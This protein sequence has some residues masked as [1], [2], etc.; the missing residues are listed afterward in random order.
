MAFKKKGDEKWEI[1]Q[2]GA[3]TVDRTVK[4]A[5]VIKDYQTTA[6]I[7]PNIEGQQRHNK[8]IHEIGADALKMQHPK[9]KPAAKSNKSNK[10]FRKAIKVAEMDD[11]GMSISLDLEWDTST[12]GSEE[13]EA[14]CEALISVF[15]SNCSPAR[16][17][18]ASRMLVK[19]L[20][21]HTSAVN[22]LSRAIQPIIHKCASKRI[23]AGRS[24]AVLNLLY[25]LHCSMGRFYHELSSFNFVGHFFDMLLVE[26]KLAA[27]LI[28]HTFRV[29]RELKSKEFQTVGVL[30]RGFGTN[31][32]IMK[33]RMSSVNARS[34][35]IRRHWNLMHC[36]LQ[37]LERMSQYGKRGPVHVIENYTLVGLQIVEFLLSN[38]AKESAQSNREDLL[39][40]NGTILLVSFISAVEG[41][42][43]ATSIAIVFHLALQPDSLPD[44]IKS[45]LVRALIRFVN[46]SWK[47]RKK[48]HISIVLKTFGRMFRHAA[49]LYRASLGYRTVVQQKYGEDTNP[50]NVNYSIVLGEFN[51]S[52]KVDLP[53]VLA[54]KEMLQLHSEILTKELT[55]ESVNIT[56]QNLL[57]LAGS[58][59]YAKVLELIIGNGGF[60]L[61]KLIDYVECAAEDEV[62]LANSI[63]ALLTQLGTFGPARSALLTSSI[64]EM[65]LP[66][67]EIHDV[68]TRAWYHKYIFILAVLCRIDSRWV[69]EPEQL[70]RD[71]N[72]NVEKLQTMIYMDMMQTIKQIPEDSGMPLGDVFVLESNAKSELEMA[73]VAERVHIRAIVDYFVRPSDSFYY[74]R[75][76]WDL[77]ACGCS[78]ISAI[79]SVPTAA[80]LA[81]SL[82]TVRYLG[83][84]FF[85]GYTELSKK[86]TS[87]K[88][89]YCL[90]TG[91]FAAVEGLARICN[92][93]KNDIS[94]SRFVV[95]GI[96]ESSAA[97]AANYFF[98][99]LAN[100]Q[101]TLKSEKVKSLQESVALNCIQFL[102][103]YSSCLTS[104]GTKSNQDEIASLA[105]TVGHS[106]TLVLNHLYLIYGQTSKFTRILDAV[107]S[108]LTNLT[109]IPIA[110]NLALKSWNVLEAL[111]IH[112]PPP[113]QEVGQFHFE[114][115]VYKNHLRDLPASF[116]SVVSN[117]ASVDHGC[118]F[119]FAEGFLRRALDKVAIM[120]AYLETEEDF[121]FQEK[122]LKLGKTVLKLNN[123]RNEV[124]ACLSLIVKCVN[125]NNPK[126]G[127]ANDMILNSNFNIVQICCDI[128]RCL[129]CPRD[130][131]ALL[132]A[133]KL[134][135]YL[136][137]DS[138]NV[139]SVFQGCGV[140]E[141]I[142]QEI[143]L[144]E[145]NKLSYDA[146]ID[147][148]DLVFNVAMG[149]RS[150]HLREYLPKM[151]ESVTKISRIH[152][153]LAPAVTE[154]LWAISKFHSNH[155]PNDTFE[156]GVVKTKEKDLTMNTD[157]NIDDE[158]VQQQIRK[159][160]TYEACGVTTC[161]GLR[162]PNITMA[163]VQQSESSMSLD[164]TFN[165]DVCEISKLSAR[166]NGLRQELQRRK[167]AL[168]F[169]STTKAK[170]SSSFSSQIT[171]CREITTAPP[172][173][174]PS[175]KKNSTDCFE[176]PKK[177]DIQKNL[178]PSISLSSFPELALTRPPK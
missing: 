32:E 44:L 84:V 6:K 174:S 137:K 76:S 167:Q 103:L 134:L 8:Y 126:W 56:V 106:A 110:I 92:V 46:H 73:S 43:C 160:G 33:S 62:I 3:T 91:C 10:L 29:H 109:S 96:T 69:Y 114:T 117:L 57:F 93:G 59:M 153:S 65:I 175:G 77:A 113:A 27:T 30:A 80:S 147:C 145:E 63:V 155:D 49:G 111:K 154:T 55:I 26:A 144:I 68:A 132:A 148:V 36:F 85:L 25:V 12:W 100:S 5:N 47:S 131:A 107:C 142:H 102:S 83:Q 99:T 101:A 71:T 98:L 173:F 130:D 54:S 115:N 171:L 48:D 4:I 18:Q 135:R 17:N 81:I 129:R 161:G 14:G 67:I 150:K 140:I 94:K 16:R 138:T 41:P 164:A 127:S 97:V 1:Q 136:S 87:E 124:A 165:S 151:R 50:S 34:A 90:L 168:G 72:D 157:L 40:I 58:Q 35:E 45:G 86:A 53:S 178:I 15:H 139:F 125:Y 123:N 149:L 169:S 37:K 122:Q 152:L 2:L 141:L 82:S 52:G 158:P 112:L 42:F 38:N 118:S 120:A 143:I 13:I 11:G 176:T 75:I 177:K 78:I 20:E 70:L 163:H 39:R 162:L 9:P 159:T 60:I 170:K 64:V 104:L 51:F 61:Q 88:K 7:I 24:V 31:T 128:I 95:A 121:E 23:R 133:I 19:L 105:E 166:D 21:R 172:S 79:C 28:Q 146:V 156:G 89:S 116:F 66:H 74:T 119:A 108:I 22:Y